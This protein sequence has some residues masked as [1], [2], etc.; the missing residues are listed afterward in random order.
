MVYFGP[1]EAPS[2]PAYI[3]M[4]NLMIAITDETYI[5]GNHGLTADG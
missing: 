5:C 1:I 2:G 3:E 4:A